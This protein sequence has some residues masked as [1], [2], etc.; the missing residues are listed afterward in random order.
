MS[1][2]FLSS[3]S[4]DKYLNSSS[5]KHSAKFDFNANQL[6]GHSQ[7]LEKTAGDLLANRQLI[8]SLHKKPQNENNS[9]AINKPEKKLTMFGASGAQPSKLDSLPKLVSQLGQIGRKTNRPKKQ[10]ICKYCYRAFTKSYNLTIHERTH[11]SE[12]ICKLQIN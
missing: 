7:L 11:T 4:S 5:D 12:W 3:Y 2:K 10:Y 9:L 1:D 8:S 6:I